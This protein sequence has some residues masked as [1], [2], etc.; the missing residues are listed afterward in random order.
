MKKYFVMSDIHSFYNQMISALNESGFDKDNPEHILIVCGDLFDRGS[1]TMEVYDFIRSLPDDRCIL[2]QGNHELLYFELLEKSFPESHDFSNGT[3]STFCH[4][5][6]YDP[7]CLSMADI[8][9]DLQAKG[10]NVTPAEVQIL[11]QNNWNKIK[12]AVIKSDVT[13]WLRSD[14]WVN[15]YELGN[16][17]FVHSF[18]P[19][20]LKESDVNSLFKYYP[21]YSMPEDW[22]EIVP[23]WRN[24]AT[25]PQWDDAKWGCPWKQFNAGLF[26][27]EMN[28]GKV[29]VCGHWHASDFHRKFEADRS[30][31]LNIFYSDALIALDAC[32]AASGFCNVLVLDFESGLC[33]DQRHKILGGLK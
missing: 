13:K 24:S 2:V 33:Y 12:K 30:N 31:N 22:L 29:L 11:I 25:Q 4:I 7:K 20:Q 16:L 19:T 3:V 28:Q 21:A 18:L 10:K 23:D 17:I 8:I 32:T 1:Q 5:A 15:Y 14:R 6:G 27:S 26:N 9:F